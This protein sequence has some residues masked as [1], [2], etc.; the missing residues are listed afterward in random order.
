MDLKDL[1]T[2]A[3]ADRGADLHLRHPGDGSPL[4]GDDGKPWAIT[5][6]G[7]DS[8]VFAREER[9]AATRR[10]ER[11]QRGEIRTPQEVE[12]EGLELLVACTK[13][14]SGNILLDGQALV[15]SPAKARELYQGWPWIREQ[16]D[17]FVGVRANYL[18]N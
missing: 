4:L 9:A 12:A 15:F 5:L 17:A 11:A 7:R 3:K 14:W 1:N 10:L 13:G 8:A 16:V 2:R 6:Y 18:G